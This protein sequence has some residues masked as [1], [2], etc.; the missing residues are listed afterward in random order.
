[1][2]KRYDYKIELFDVSTLITEPE[3]FN[4]WLNNWLDNGYELV[5]FQFDNVRNLGFNRIAGAGIFKKR[6]S[7]GKLRQALSSVFGI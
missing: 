7:G 2:G 5:S 3:E 4:L 6:I 1:M